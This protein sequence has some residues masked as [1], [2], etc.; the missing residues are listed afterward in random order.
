[1][2]KIYV[3]PLIVQGKPYTCT[4]I[5][6]NCIHYLEKLYTNYSKHELQETSDQHDVV[7]GPHGYDDA[8]YHMLQS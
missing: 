6:F 5:I 3:W 7:D 8:L 2:D 4:V 1:M